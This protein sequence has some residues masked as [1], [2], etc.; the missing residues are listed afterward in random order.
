[1]WW[2]SKTERAEPKRFIDRIDKLEPPV[3]KSRT[4]IELL[5]TANDRKEIELPAWSES[6][7]ETI[8]PSCVVL[9][10]DKPLPNYM[11]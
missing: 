10:T 6:K 4:D 11:K 9:Q 1:M 5:M 2:K 8:E 7:T 3:Q